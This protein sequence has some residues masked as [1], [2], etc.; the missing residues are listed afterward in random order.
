MFDP[1]DV[2]VY[3]WL[4]YFQFSSDPHE[5]REGG[6]DGS[7]LSVRFHPAPRT[8]ISELRIPSSAPLIRIMLAVVSTVPSFAPA[9][10]AGNGA[11][12]ARSSAT[13]MA[14]PARQQGQQCGIGGA[15]AGVLA[16]WDAWPLIW[17]SI[18]GLLSACAKVAQSTARLPFRR[19]GAMCSQT[20]SPHMPSAGPLTGGTLPVDD[21]GSSSAGSVRIEVMP[22]SSDMGEPLSSTSSA[23]RPAS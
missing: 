16:A 9:P 19:A 1:H 23:I 21:S 12:Q 6:Y 20:P 14:R 11:V 7:S 22:D 15:T 8:L 18:W 3:V 13:M 5:T 2:D 17:D 10:L 4:T